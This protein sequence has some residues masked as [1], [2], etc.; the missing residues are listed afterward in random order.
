MH[1]LVDERGENLFHIEKYGL[2][3]HMDY[4]IPYF[5]MSYQSTAHLNNCD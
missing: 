3:I 1:D 2:L 5:L 4:N